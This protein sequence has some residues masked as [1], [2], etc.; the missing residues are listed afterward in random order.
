M[1]EI[2]PNW[3]PM[4]VHFT[5]ASFSTACVLYVL[6]YVFSSRK[7]AP[8]KIVSEIEIVGRW[9]LWLAAFIT[10]GTVLAGLYAFN[11]VRHDEAAHIAMI[12]HR[13]WALATATGIVLLAIWSGRHHYKNKKP[14]IIFIAAL[15]AVQFSLL[16]TAWFGGELVYRHGLGVMS[17]PKT[18]G[19]GH[20]HHSEEMKMDHSN[21]PSMENPPGHDH[22]K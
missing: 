2:I 21:M 13:K 9:C 5:V 16:T 19:E 4:F 14:A 1:I 6:A 15:L 20:H 3:H 22:M 7:I 11:T 10:V 17:L 12:I 18:E 8:L